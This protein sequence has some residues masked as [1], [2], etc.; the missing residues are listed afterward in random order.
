MAQNSWN[1]RERN[2]LLLNR[3]QGRFAEVGGALGLD[4]LADARGM[5]AADFDQDGD[6]D[7]LVNN[8][9]AKAAYYVNE[10]A[11]ARSVSVR[12]VGADG[13]RDA[14]GAELT[15]RIGDRT[16]HRLVGAG[17]SYASQ[18]SLAQHIGLA[19]ADRVDALV[20]RWPSGEIEEFPGPPAG[21]RVTLT[22]GDG[23]ARSSRATAES[24]I[25]SAG[26]PWLWLGLGVL[27]VGVALVARL[28]GLG[29]GQ[30]TGA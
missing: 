18:F 25:S 10:H 8:Y 23:L 14:I 15:A 22:R 6:I 7:I 21:A 17:H 29:Q 26:F 3:G 28:G 27:I 2:H 30:R 11:T 12:L 9:K 1:G 4:G 13:N 5:A 19:D 20:V 16:L 24:G